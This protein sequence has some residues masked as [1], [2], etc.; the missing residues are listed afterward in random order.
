MASSAA[1][2]VGVGLGASVAVGCGGQPCSALPTAVTRISIV[3]FPLP[4]SK[5][6]QNESGVAPRAMFTPVT[7]LTTVT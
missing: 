5:A 6:G 7:M 1:S 2:P 3:T 4:L